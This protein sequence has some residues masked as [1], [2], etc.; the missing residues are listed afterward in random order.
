MSTKGK[1]RKPPRIDAELRK[2]IQRCGLS[3]YAVC[4]RTGIDKAVL[5]RFLSGDRDVTLSTA[6]TIAEAL[7]LRLVADNGEA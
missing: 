1:Q 4:Q 5:S 2:A 3:Q 6:A 7:G